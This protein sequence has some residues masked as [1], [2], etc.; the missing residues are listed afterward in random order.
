LL[1]LLR[2]KKIK[3]NQ[4]VG[5]NDGPNHLK[6]EFCGKEIGYMADLMP[7]GSLI[8]DNI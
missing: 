5:C 1:L 2:R 3:K 6:R 8:C 7:S 4:V